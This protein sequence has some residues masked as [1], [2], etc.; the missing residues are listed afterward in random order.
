V[1]DPACPE[2]L[3][4]PGANAAA[5]ELTLFLARVF[6]SRCPLLNSPL[7]FRR[8]LVQQI[9]RYGR[10]KLLDIGCGDPANLADW[11]EIAEASGVDLFPTPAA[12]DQERYRE[13]ANDG[14]FPFADGRF[15]VAVGLFVLEHAPDLRALIRETVRVVR[16]GGSAM[17]VTTH[18][19]LGA[20][21]WASL[22]PGHFRGFSSTSQ[23]GPAWL[24][25]VEA[26]LRCFSEAGFGSL[27]AS[28][29]RLSGG[30]LLWCDVASGEQ[31][32]IEA[33]KE[34]AA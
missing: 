26:L 9:A 8:Q 16:A 18:C 31:L 5:K 17:F 4:R 12:V 20:E 29:S 7:V 30:A 2:Q 27:S 22:S 28:G 32:W 10:T 13:L 21:P 25:T 33:R 24:M 23:G 11:D 3:T 6:G 1:F 34:G 19:P 15:D 14:R